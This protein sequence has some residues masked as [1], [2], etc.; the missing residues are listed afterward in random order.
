MVGACTVPVQM[1]GTCPQMSLPHVNPYTRQPQLC[2]MPFGNDACPIGYECVR[3]SRGMA[4]CCSAPPRC[5]MPESHLFHDG[6]VAFTGVVS[7]PKYCAPE[8]VQS[9]PAGYTCQQ[10]PTKEHICCTAP[11]RCPYGMSA[12]R[13]YGLGE[14]R[15][16]APQT[17]GSCPDEYR[18][19]QSASVARMHLCCM[20][21][22]FCIMPYV[23]AEHSRTPT[24]CVPGNSDCAVG[25]FCLPLPTAAGEPHVP[26]QLRQYFCC[27]NIRVAQC[28][29]GRPP[30]MDAAQRLPRHCNMFNPN[31]CPT[32]YACRRLMDGTAGC[33]RPADEQV[34]RELALAPAVVTAEQQPSQEPACKIALLSN[35]TWSPIACEGVAD[36]RTCIP[37]AKCRRASDDKYY[38]CAMDMN[39]A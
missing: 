26:P 16:C 4:I 2:Q 10:S 19:V 9:C 30:L 39:R 24:E 3:T 8:D 38:C 15:T 1:T 6:S 7:P 13:D 33:C 35:S 5:P 17:P 11:F 31:S 27:L 23:D 21:E 18:C 12:L 29:D 34:K 28:D 32:A 14:P 20:P 36:R 37:N 25:T 22:Q